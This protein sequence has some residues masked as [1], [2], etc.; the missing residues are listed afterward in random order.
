MKPLNLLILL[1]FLAGMVWVIALSEESVRSIQASYYRIIAPFVKGGSQLELKANAFLKEVEYSKDLEERL[2][3]TELEFGR[4]GAIEGQLRELERENN[5]LNAALDFKRRTEFTVTAA[6][7]I[8]RQPSTW[9]KT[10][11]IDR[12]A[13]SG[14]ARQV[15]VL[16]SGGLAG[17][18]D[19]V[20]PGRDE[21]SVILL[22]DE[23]CQV[24]VQVEGTPEV[25]IVSG[26]RGQIGE[27]PLLRLRYLSKDAPIRPGMKVV[28]TGRGGLF[29]PKILVGMIE[30]FEPGAFDGEALVKP[31][32]DFQ[33]LS[34]VFV[35]SA[36]DNTSHEKSKEDE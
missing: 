1:G 36:P 35:T 5:E 23:S 9:W 28:T 8:R 33:N 18:V 15:P 25:G 31:S 19:R 30:S 24:S 12:G 29:H 16:A 13:M 34:I 26:Q 20:T 32:V 10:I 4:L 14:I 22:T 2:H 17:K 21:S 6:R 11:E 7:V 27:A 3:R